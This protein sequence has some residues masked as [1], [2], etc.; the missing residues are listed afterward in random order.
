M[1]E[2]FGRILSIDP[3]LSSVCRLSEINYVFYV[4][5]SIDKTINCYHKRGNPKDEEPICSIGLDDY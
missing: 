4:T 1:K 3:D 2:S 5:N